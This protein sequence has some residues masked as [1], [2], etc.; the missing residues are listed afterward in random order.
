PVRQGRG[1]GGKKSEIRISKSESR[2]PKLEIR[3]K[4]EIQNP[5]RREMI[6]LVFQPEADHLFVCVTGISNFFRISRFGF[7]IFILCGTS[8]ASPDY[9]D[10]SF[11]FRFLIT[12]PSPS[13]KRAQPDQSIFS[14]TTLKTRTFTP[15]RKLTSVVS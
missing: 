12:F 13:V 5:K 2:N 11:T 15:L 9:F 3:N 1:H 7:R 8:S 4:L 10:V 14:F 6:G